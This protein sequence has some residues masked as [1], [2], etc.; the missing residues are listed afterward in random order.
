[1]AA[2]SA[3]APALRSPEFGLAVGLVLGRFAFGM[4][5]LHYGYW[6]PDL[7]VTPENLG[8]AQTRYTDLLIADIPSGVHSILDIGCGAGH[9]AARLLDLGYRVDCVSPNPFLT[10]EARA[11]LGARARVFES[12]FE[13]LD[14]D[15]SYDLLL[16]SESFLFMASG[17]ALARARALLQPGGYLLISDLFRLPTASRGP[18][19]GGK[20]LEA[21]RA[22]MATTPFRLLR[23]TDLTDGI[24]PTF[25]LL[26]RAYVEAIEPTY[27]LVEARLAAEHPWWFRVLRLGFGRALRRYE[28]KHFSGERDAAHFRR[29]KSYR[30]M[31]Y[32]LEP[33]PG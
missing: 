26:S 2:P 29:Y 28:A 3:G 6:E 11:L 5:D 14:L 15:G 9:T 12:R 13:T 10:R 33:A 32:R 21:H 19:G 8:R 22:L 20:D 1:M 4:R 31:L 18:I 27:R 16:F 17:P 30:R 25:D 7:P 23:D 24:A